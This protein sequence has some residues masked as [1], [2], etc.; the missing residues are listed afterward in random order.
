VNERMLIVVSFSLVTIRKALWKVGKSKGLS[1]P[2][3]LLA[4]KMKYS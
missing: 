1:S 2:H 4:E 3:M